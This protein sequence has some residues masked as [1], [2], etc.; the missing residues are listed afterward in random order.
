MAKT[1]ENKKLLALW[2]K[3]QQ[4]YRISILEERTL[5]EQWYIHLS[6]W[7]TI[8]ILALIFVITMILFSLLILFTP[9]KNYLPGY[10]A[11][12]RKELI[13]ESTRVDS[14]GTALEL[15]RQYLYTIKQIVAG[16]VQSDTVKSL[17]SMQIITKAK[18]LE[19]KSKAT[20]E[21]IAQYEN[22]DRS[23]VSLFDS[24]RSEKSL[25]PLFFTPVH[26]A[27]ITHFSEN[28][29]QLGIE[30]KAPV[31][32]NISAV[33]AGTII[34]V[35]HEVNDAYTIIIQHDQYLSIYRG[36]GK[37]LKQQGE[38]VRTGEA[39]GVSNDNILGFELWKNNQAINPEQM[40]AF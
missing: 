2:K 28:H 9:I 6:G 34:Y 31:N 29:R 17:D 7:N 1:I 13:I 24:M 26:G 35:N 21:F 19:V 12:I 39:I 23:D 8:V 33:L 14:M 22:K 11:D 15:Q 32:E 18:L 37:L 36:I 30:I 3:L 10:S 38:K 5:T 4:K 27:I 16:E 25:K 20:E 40:I